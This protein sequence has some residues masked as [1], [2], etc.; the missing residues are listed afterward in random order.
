MIHLIYWTIFRISS[1]TVG[2]I[3]L[4]PIYRSGF[5]LLF[6]PESGQHAY[7]TIGSKYRGYTAHYAQF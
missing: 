5:F 2:R 4:N 3:L 6:D 7:V 1:Y